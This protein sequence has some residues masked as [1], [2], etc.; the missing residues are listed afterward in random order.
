MEGESQAMDFKALPKIEVNSHSQIPKNRSVA[1]IGRSQQQLHAHL[2]GSISR[3]C[4][5][6]VW[7]KKKEAGETDLTDPL[8]EMPLGKHDYDL[9]T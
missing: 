5:H 9:K 3:Q 6:E 8:I 4:L 2:S 1:N 7:L